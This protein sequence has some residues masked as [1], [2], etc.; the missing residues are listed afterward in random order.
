MD[1]KELYQEVIM[2]HA[3]KPRNFGEPD[4]CDVQIHADNPMCGDDLT[5]FLG[6]DGDSVRDI[7]FTGNACSICMA[8]ASLMTLKTRGKS[9]AE[10]AELSRT[11]QDMITAPE[12]RLPDDLSSLGD[13]QA[14]EGVRKF[15]MRAKCAT[16]PWHALDDALQALVDGERARGIS[17][18]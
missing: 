16:L 6:T 7:H 10:L 11:F 1:L 9:Q 4:E 2:D 8:S 17:V 5:L 14:L 13:L 12:E 3:R 18:Q 15:P